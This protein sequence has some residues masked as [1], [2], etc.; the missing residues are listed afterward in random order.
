LSLSEAYAQVIGIDSQPVLSMGRWPDPILRQA[1]S[2][3]ASSVFQNKNKL[4]QLQMVAKALRNTAR[5]EGAVG[6]AAQQCGVDTS[7]LFIDGVKISI[8]KSARNDGMTGGMF[9]ETMNGVFGQSSWQKSQKEI[10]VEGVYVEGSP[11][12]NKWPRKSKQ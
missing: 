9:G 8:S 10:T 11:I 12:L 4:E 2:T 1:S 6:L 5:N 3:I 7:L